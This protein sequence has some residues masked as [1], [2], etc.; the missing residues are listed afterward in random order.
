[1][2]AIPFLSVVTPSLKCSPSGLRERFFLASLSRLR[3]SS[4]TWKRR[5]MP[6]SRCLSSCTASSTPAVARG[7]RSSLTCPK[8]SPWEATGKDDPFGCFLLA[9]LLFQRCPVSGA[10]QAFPFSLADKKRLTGVL[11][12]RTVGFI[13][14]YH[15][16][17]N[18]WTL[19]LSCKR[20]P[21]VS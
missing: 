20:Q 16:S 12:S 5:G 21:C 7:K 13:S 9:N 1:M 18:L 17:Q 15:L 3:F 11:E 10:G 6:W 2:W 19:L 8:C 4:A 14:R